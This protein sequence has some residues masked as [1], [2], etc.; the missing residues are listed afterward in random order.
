MKRAS[1]LVFFSLF[2]CLLASAS[3]VNAGGF[4]L[5]EWSNRGVA[6]ATTGYAIAGDA[7][8]IATNPALM[9]KLEGKHGLAG[10]VVI[11]PQST[12][13]VDGHK[14]KTKANKFVV[15]HLYYTQQMESNENVWLGIG[16]F[17]RFGLGTEYDKDWN[18]KASLQD[19]ELESVSVNP[20]I[21]FKLSDQLSLAVGIE[22]LRGGIKLNQFPGVVVS[23]NTVGYG[24]GGNLAVHYDF[25]DQWSA[26]LTW[27]A[28]MKLVT[29][30]SG[31]KGAL[32]SA[33]AG[34][35]I[36]STLPGSYT[37]GI[38]Y[39]PF[40]NWSWEFDVLHTR[41]DSVDAMT[42]SG[43]I[44][45]EHELHYKNTWRF[46][47][48]T[49]YWAKE[50]LALRFGYVYDQTPTSGGY[51][52]FMLPA[53]DRQLFSTGLGFKWD[54]WTADW[55]F[56]YVTTKERKGLGIEK[57]TAPGTN[58]RVDFTNGKTW[59]TGLSLGYQF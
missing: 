32:N 8:V 16:V 6:M 58:Y 30:G 53:N 29:E 45:K 9:T 55:S 54:K 14:N 5:Y 17:T 59:I 31:Q 38:G 37:L 1:V 42:Y 19:V 48:G 27:R 24:I 7:S 22:I 28:P 47:L 4:A 12:V 13:T 10:A 41:W 50:W 25:N 20:N 39:K 52:S 57:P 43:I 33:T 18:G 36:E 51:A 2:V 34:Q 40:E 46:Q 11:A 35:T 49:E 23:A 56:M 15:P 26:G 44:D 3:V 21:A